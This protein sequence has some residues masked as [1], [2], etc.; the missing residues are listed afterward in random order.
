ML[1]KP[2]SAVD[3]ARVREIVALAGV[4][5][6]VLFVNLVLFSAWPAQADDAV[7]NRTTV[8]SRMDAMLYPEFR[9][10]AP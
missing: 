7:A 8:P 4:A 10:S 5:L 1:Y 2:D 3:C 6:M 9:V